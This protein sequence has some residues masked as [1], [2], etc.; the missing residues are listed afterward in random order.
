MAGKTVIKD[1]VARLGFEVDDSKLEEFERGLSGLAATAGAVAGAVAGAAATVF[2]WAKNAA[3]AAETAVLEANALGLT[4]EAYQSLAYA[5]EQSGVSAE[6][7]RASLTKAALS[8]QQAIRGNAELAGTF[9]ELGLSAEEFA[10]L[11]ADEKLSVLADALAGVEEPGRR[12]GIA[13]QLLGEQGAR[14]ATLLGEGSAGIE[15]LRE[16]AVSLGL[17]LSNE[18]AAAGE[19]FG[20]TLARVGLVVAGVKNTIGLELVP[21][22]EEVVERFE[23]WFIANREI[24]RANLV[25]MLRATSAAVLAVFRGVWRLVEAVQAVVDAFGGWDAVLQSVRVILIGLVGY[26]AIAGIRSL[27]ATVQAAAAAYRAFGATALLANAKA[28]AGP[29]AIGAAIAA[30]VLI[31]QDFVTFLRGGD[32][33]IGRFVERFAE[34]DGVLGTVARWLLDLRDVI[35]NWPANWSLIVGYFRDL[36]QGAVDAVAGMIEGLVAVASRV[37]SATRSSFA[38]VVGAIVAV[39]QGAVDAVSAVFNAIAAVVVWYVETTRSNFETV[40]AFVVDAFSRIWTF[41]STVFE[42]LLAGPRALGDVFA[43]VLAGIE[44]GAR[45]VFGFLV[46]GIA[47]LVDGFLRLA[48][49]GGRALGFDTD[50]IANARAGLD[51]FRANVAGGTGPAPVGDVAPGGNVSTSLSVGS[52]GVSVQGTTGM[53]PEDLAR[54]TDVGVRRALESEL[55]RLSRSTAGAE[56]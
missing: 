56:V 1:L 55:V 31:V 50:T 28:L 34:T 18:A 46:D 44:G 22:V 38:A 40:V 51:N 33:L 11:G 21:I 25:G 15:A 10:A 54:A 14:L 27:V 45:R 35:D 26:Q 24:L 41:V 52:I 17:V 37:G 49:V 20:D 3:E 9:R 29:L 5:A 7:L 23:E 6:M 19:N 43:T 30:L 4:A 48:E 53:G 47:N 16:E 2:A 12:T 13:V 36:W 8:A 42:A 32:S 39:W